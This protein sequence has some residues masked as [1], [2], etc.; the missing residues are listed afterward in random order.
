MSEY[1]YE[2]VEVEIFETDDEGDAASES[3]RLPDTIQVCLLKKELLNAEICF[4]N[5]KF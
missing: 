1:T 3:S 5:Q 2:E 4:S